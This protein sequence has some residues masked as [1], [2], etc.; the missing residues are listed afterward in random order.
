MDAPKLLEKANPRLLGLRY[1]S[2]EVRWEFKN[3]RVSC[4]L[5]S[6]IITILSKRAGPYFFKESRYNLVSALQLRTDVTM[7][8]LLFTG[9]TE[10]NS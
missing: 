7:V 1:S 10:R 9:M 5:P 3:S 2:Y 4:S 6:S 8:I